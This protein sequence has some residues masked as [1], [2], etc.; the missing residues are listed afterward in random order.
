MKDYK[1]LHSTLTVFKIL[2][3]DEMCLLIDALLMH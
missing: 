3:N 1:K 2:K